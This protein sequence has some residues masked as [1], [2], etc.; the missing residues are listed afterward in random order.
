MVRPDRPSTV[1][2]RGA[3]TA[4]PVSRR[5]AIVALGAVG[6]A[7][8]AGCSTGTADGSDE[9][10][11]LADTAD[12]TPGSHAAFAFELDRERYVTVSATL[13]DRSVE[14]KHDGPAVDVLV[15]TPDQYRAFRSG[16]S[17][18][19]VGG[20]SMPGVVAGTVSS[21]LGAGDYRTVVDHSAA[22]AGE[23][24]D[25]GTPAIVDLEVTASTGRSRETVGVHP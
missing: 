13:S 11:L 4:L 8:I 2:R 9:R 12:V 24:D 21:S 17:P 20:V 25:T 15:M 18:Q 16:E 23:P 1:E 19:Y 10:T 22:G 6:T 7:A 14:V 3:K 5:D